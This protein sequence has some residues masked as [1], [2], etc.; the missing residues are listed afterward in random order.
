MREN[1]HNQ[2]VG[3]TL[4]QKARQTASKPFAGLFV[5]PPALRREERVSHES[6]L[7]GPSA[8]IRI[9]IAKNSDRRMEYV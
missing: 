5:F 2:F 6:E 8:P 9:F 3:F 7:P 4:P 1:P